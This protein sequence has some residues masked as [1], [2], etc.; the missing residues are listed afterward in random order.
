MSLEEKKKASD[1][2]KKKF[3]LEKEKLEKKEFERRCAEKL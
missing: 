3:D 1:L 2:A